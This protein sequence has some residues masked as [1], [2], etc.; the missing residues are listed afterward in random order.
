MAGAMLEAGKAPSWIAASA[1]MTKEVA[2]PTTA[3]PAVAPSSLPA[4]ERSL[5]PHRRFA[6]KEIE[7]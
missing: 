1:A 3:T 7:G 4:K 5:R 2:A 6:L